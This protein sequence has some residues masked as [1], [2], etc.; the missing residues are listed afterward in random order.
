MMAAKADEYAHFDAA[1]YIDGIDDAYLQIALEDSADDPTMVRALGVI[2][3][4]QDMTKL[5]RRSAIARSGLRM[6]RPG[7][8]RNRHVAPLEQPS[9][10]SRQMSHQIPPTGISFRAASRGEWRAGSP[11]WAYL[12]IPEHLQELCTKPLASDRLP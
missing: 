8:C 5:T 2:A 9:E 11:G 6:P 7:D 12:G 4:S 3:R 10:M 1:D